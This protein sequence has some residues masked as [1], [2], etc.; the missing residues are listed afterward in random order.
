MP[1]VFHQ[2]FSCFS[3]S[4]QGAWDWGSWSSMA[5]N[6]HKS[7]LG[8]LSLKSHHVFHFQ[9]FYPAFN[10]SHLLINSL[11]CCVLKNLESA[12]RLLAGLAGLCW[13]H[14]LWRSSRGIELIRVMF[15]YLLTPANGMVDWNHLACILK[16]AVY[17]DFIGPQYASAYLQPCFFVMRPGPRKAGWRHCFWTTGQ[18]W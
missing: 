16:A 2:S 6:H 13:V 15:P 8:T 12:P 4:R 10:R 3:R 9:K 18:R 5:E 11:T 7:V 17:V 1:S 14:Y